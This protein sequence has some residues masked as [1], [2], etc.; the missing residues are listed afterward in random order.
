MDLV[1]ITLL[2]EGLGQLLP[3]TTRSPGPHI[4]AIIHW[5]CIRQ[6]IFQRDTSAQPLQ[7]EWAELGHC[8]EQAHVARLQRS[9]PD[10]YTTQHEVTRDGIHGTLDLIDTYDWSADEIKA[11]WMSP[12]VDPEDDRWWRYWAQ[13]MAY[14]YMID[15]TLARIHI[16]HVAGYD[17]PIH[18]IWQREYTRGEL[19]THWGLITSA[20]DR[21]EAE[22]ETWANA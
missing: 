4:S 2:S 19:V 5:L 16:F 17:G 10:R 11:S 3:P 14:C 12:H 15:S 8:I 22:G 18:R 21:M 1:T 13:V 9:D 20:R 6:G 7:G